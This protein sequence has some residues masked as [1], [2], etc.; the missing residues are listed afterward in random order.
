[1]SD[2][3]NVLG[4]VKRNPAGAEH[5]FLKDYLDNLWEV[6]EHKEVFRHEQSVTGGICGV[7]IGV[8]NMEESLKVYG[9]LLQYDKTIYD[10]TDT[11]S[12]LGSLPG[13]K[14]K[15]RRLMLEH[16]DTRSG[17]FSP[18]FGSSCIELVQSLDMKPRN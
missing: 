6:T 17:A 18:F 4:A 8:E 5:F 10:M 9:E 12:D 11:F 2:G 3:L 15:F 14:G 16:S 13:G 1:T 7:V